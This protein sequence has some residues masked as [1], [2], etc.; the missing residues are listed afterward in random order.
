MYCY[1]WPLVGY[2]NSLEVPLVVAK[3]SSN[4]C[5]TLCLSLYS[6]ELQLVLRA[7]LPCV[8]PV[9]IGQGLFFPACLPYWCSGSSQNMYVTIRQET[10]CVGALEKE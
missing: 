9:F 1:G 6:Q 8:V 4:G 5:L 10:G 3:S 7:E 2:L